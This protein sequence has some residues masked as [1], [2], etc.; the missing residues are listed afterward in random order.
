L[1]FHISLV[2]YG[3]SLVV[4]FLSKV[5]NRLEAVRREDFRLSLTALQADIQKLSS[6]HQA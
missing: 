5:G 2:E 3:F 6:V 4:Y 1:L